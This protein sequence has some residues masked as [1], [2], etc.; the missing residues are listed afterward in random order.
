MARDPAGAG[1]RHQSQ[2]GGG[3]DDV[4]RGRAAWRRPRVTSLTRAAGIGVAR[5][6]WAGRE[7]DS[8]RAPRGWLCAGRRWWCG[9]AAGS[10]SPPLRAGEGSALGAGRPG[11]GRASGPGDR[12][13]PRR[14][15]CVRAGVTPGESRYGLPTLPRRLGPAACPRLGASAH[16]VLP[17]PAPGAPLAACPVPCP[18]L[19][20]CAALGAGRGGRARSGGATRLGRG[21]CL[22]ISES[23]FLVWVR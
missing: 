22:Q 12:D 6:T 5:C 23:C 4:G 10:W 18:L 9:E 8:W 19:G 1:E 7:G 13:S 20:R 3:R 2:P 14:R 17:R 15:S 16:L 11:C 21:Q